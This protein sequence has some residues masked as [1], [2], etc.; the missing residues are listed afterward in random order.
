MLTRSE[1][2][3]DSKGLWIYKLEDEDYANLLMSV[4]ISKG[5]TTELENKYT[6]E[7]LNNKG[8]KIGKELTLLEEKFNKVSFFAFT[9]D[10][11]KNKI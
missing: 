5:R 8:G 9:L 6:Y 10:N 4:F 3:E 7:K 1:A 2:N 11:S